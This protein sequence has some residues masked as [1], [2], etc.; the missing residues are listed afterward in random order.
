MPFRCSATNTFPLE[1]GATLP[2][3]RLTAAALGK[4]KGQ[5]ILGHAISEEPGIEDCANWLRTFITETPIRFVRASEP[6]WSPK[7]GSR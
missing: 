4:N 3:V 5:I 2:A 6:F 1:S 7:A